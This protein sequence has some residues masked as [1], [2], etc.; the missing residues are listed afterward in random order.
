MSRLSIQPELTE[1]LLVDFI[2]REV[3]RTGLRRAV[4]GVSGGL[5][6]AVVLVL[7]AR[8]LGA[9][10]VLAVLLPYR[11]SAASSERDGLA[12]LRGLKV[13]H[14]RV[15]ISPM[16]DGYFRRLPR[17]DRQRRGNKM[18]RERM[19]ILY[20]LSAQWKGLVLGT[21]N[22]SEMLLGYGTIHGDLACALHPIGD[23]YKTQVR[24]LARHLGVPARI[25]RK[26][27]S[28][29][30]YPGQTDESELGYSYARVDRLLHFL[31]DVRGGKREAIAAGFPPKMIDRVL[32]QIRRSQY[33]RRMP[34][35]AKVSDRTI[36]V[37]FRYPR[38]WGN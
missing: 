34:L 20:D 35:I 25:L 13:P 2:R 26:A 31:V 4:V 16:V 14:L 22:K 37:D 5:D 15:D 19:A 17:A 11:T 6:S 18:A 32:E 30:L 10:S 12:L 24:R 9:A 8:A 38:D 3:R 36:G 28:A 21:S 23:L 29:D 7:A 27:P 33:K 1:A